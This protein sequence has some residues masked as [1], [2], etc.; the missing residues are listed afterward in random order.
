MREVTKTVFI[1]IIFPYQSV[2][3]TYYFLP[4]VVA[5]SVFSLTVFVNY[6]YG[7]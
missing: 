2:K 4:L 6:V 1:K 5:V 3:K 7:N